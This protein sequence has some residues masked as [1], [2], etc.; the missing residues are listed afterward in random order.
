MF[1]IHTIAVIIIDI[2]M[3]TFLCFLA[4]LS[5]ICSFFIIN[6]IT[7]IIIPI[8]KGNIRMLYLKLSIICPFNISLSALVKP[9]PGHG[10]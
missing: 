6:K 7:Y 2:I 3:T 10:T 5:M 4:K 8:K 1:I 9:H